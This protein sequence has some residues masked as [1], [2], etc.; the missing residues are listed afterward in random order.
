MWYTITKSFTFDAAHHLPNHDGKCRRPHGHTYRMDV[1]LH[2]PVHPITPD[3]EG[4]RRPDEGMI[5]DFTK[6][7]LIVQQELL[8]HMDHYDLNEAI[9]ALDDV[10]TAERLAEFCLRVLHNECKLVT[11]VRIYETRDSYAEVEWQN[12]IDMDFNIVGST[13]DSPEA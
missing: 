12:G 8:T 13:E 7:K 5:M 3:N 4:Y 1:T 9:P 6:L 11:K 2:G 10:T